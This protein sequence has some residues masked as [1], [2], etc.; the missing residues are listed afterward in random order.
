MSA[1]LGGNTYTIKAFGTKSNAPDSLKLQIAVISD[2]HIGGEREV[3]KLTQA[4]KDY[5]KTTPNYNVL[6]VVGDLTNHGLDTQYDSF[7]KTLN[8]NIRPSAEKILA[9]GNH[10]YFEGKNWPKP[11][12]T[13]KILMDRFIKKTGMPGVYYDKWIKG[14]HFITL[15]GE[16][17]RISNPDNGDYAVISE[18]QYSWLE[19]TLPIGLDPKKPIFVFLHQPLDD[20]VYG[21][22]FW[23]AGLKDMRL[24]NILSRYPQVILFSGH[25]HCIL[26]NPKT[27]YQEGF[28]MVN[29]ASTAYT[30]SEDTDKA[31]PY[32]QGI[33]VNVYDNMVEI[34]AREFTNSTWIN[35]FKIDF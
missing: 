15:G 2:V 19:N 7:M 20:T 33:L 1:L 10:E 27:V 5:G 14:Y 26:T 11:G 9:M 25:S 18:A 4:L 17:S 29:T 23:G 8:N 13:D 3:S 24:F 34:K 12:L 6:A 16:Q 30:W 28:T 22:H 31:L 35:T 32:S 21:S